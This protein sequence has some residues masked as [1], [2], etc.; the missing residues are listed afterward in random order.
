[1]N[2]PTPAGSQRQQKA[3]AIRRGPPINPLKLSL[4]HLHILVGVD[5]S[6]IFRT[7]ADQPIVA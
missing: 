2:N 7:R 4:F 3:R 1:M 5:R 6:L